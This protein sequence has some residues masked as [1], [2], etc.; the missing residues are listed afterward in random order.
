[1]PDRNKPRLASSLSLVFCSS[2]FG[3]LC[4]EKE[5]KEGNQKAKKKKS[6]EKNESSIRI[7]MKRPKQKREKCHN[8]HFNLFSIIQLNNERYCIFL[9]QSRSNTW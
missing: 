1:M 6:Q 5:K 7:R 8:S 9:I 4:E 3:F 2:W